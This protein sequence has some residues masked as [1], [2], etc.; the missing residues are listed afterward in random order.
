MFELKKSDCVFYEQYSMGKK[1]SHM[2]IECVPLGR[3]VSNVAPGYFKV[4]RILFK[5]N[6]IYNNSLFSISCFKESFSRKRK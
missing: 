1:F 5:I 3:N 4:I 2:A 6:F